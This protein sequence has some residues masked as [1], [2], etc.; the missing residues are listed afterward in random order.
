MVI[1]AIVML[2]ISSQQLSSFST[3]AQAQASGN[4]VKVAGELSKSD[5]IIYNPEKDANYFSFYLTDESGETQ[6]VI[7]KKPKPRDFERSESIVLT[8]KWASTHFE[9]SEMLLKCPSKYK[10]EE[11][12]LRN[13]VKISAVPE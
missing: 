6:Q 1:I 13:Q 8:G 5:P 12:A 2:V 10:N 4:R 11:L 9:A 7:I 3:F